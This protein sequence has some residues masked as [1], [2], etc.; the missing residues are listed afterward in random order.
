[1]KYV[2]DLEFIHRK[3]K[4]RARESRADR[5][6]REGLDRWAPAQCTGASPEKLP[7]LKEA[8]QDKFTYQPFLLE[9]WIDGHLRSAPAP[10]TLPNLSKRPCKTNSAYTSE[11][12]QPAR[13]CK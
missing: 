11:A 13:L 7:N 3:A 1:M 9:G 12:F 10:E 6:D 4:H 5:W 2:R 8:L